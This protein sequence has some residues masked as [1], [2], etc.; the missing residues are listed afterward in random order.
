MYRCRRE[1]LRS[2]R[3]SSRGRGAIVLLAGL[4]AGVLGSAPFAEAQCDPGFE[5]AVRADVLAGKAPLTVIFRG[6]VIG[7]SAN[8]AAVSWDFDDGGT[9]GNELVVRHIYS[10]AGDYLA[11]FTGTNTTT[12]CSAS[13][14]VLI[15][16]N[17]V[18]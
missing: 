1:S 9:A 18:L 17:E 10:Q 7:P 15:Q 11:R 5:V 14:T 13:T 3:G 2:A 4:L 8:D 16:V 12:G 6:G